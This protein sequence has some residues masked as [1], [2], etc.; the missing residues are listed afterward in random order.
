M[1]VGPSNDALSIRPI[2]GAAIR[3]PDRFAF[4][5][6]FL[7]NDTMNNPQNAVRILR[8][9][10]EQTKSAVLYHYTRR[11]IPAHRAAVG[12]WI[13]HFRWLDKKSGYTE[14]LKQME[15]TP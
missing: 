1:R 6:L 3:R 14:A 8:G 15:T 9:S 4:C 13:A 2:P 10:M 11:K 12:M 5:Y 7:E